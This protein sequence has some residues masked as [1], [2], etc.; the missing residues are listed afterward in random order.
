MEGGYS[1]FVDYQSLISS[2]FHLPYPQ[3]FIL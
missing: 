2:I 3:S 1:V